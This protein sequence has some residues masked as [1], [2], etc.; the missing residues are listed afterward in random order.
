[1]QKTGKTW[2]KAT[3]RK[4]L[5]RH[6]KRCK[7]WLAERELLVTRRRRRNTG[8]RMT[9]TWRTGHYVIDSREVAIEEDNF[10]SLPELGGK[11][12]SIKIDDQVCFATIFNIMGVLFIFKSLKSWSPKA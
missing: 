7:M 11:I 4:K 6:A 12:S 2:S 10:P 3:I 5:R 9:V 8:V 1:M